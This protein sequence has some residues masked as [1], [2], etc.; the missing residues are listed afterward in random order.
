MTD[1]RNIA[2]AR[3]VV[4]Q[5]AE[6]LRG[7]TQPPVPGGLQKPE[8]G[9]FASALASATALQSTTS[10]TPP[11]VAP[12]AGVPAAGLVSTLS[13]LL[14]RVNATQVREDV[15]TESYQR[16]EITDVASVALAEQEASVS[17]E[18]TLQV[19]NKLLSAYGEI[20]RMQV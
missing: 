2:G 14:G 9:A 8:P 3:E 16:G 7:L 4:L 5:R 20:M 15:V 18:A 1:I 11:V 17:F 13:S 19:R 10:L 12:D 6:A